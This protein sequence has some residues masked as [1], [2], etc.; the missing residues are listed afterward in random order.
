MANKYDLKIASVT[1]SGVDTYEAVGDKVDKGKTRFV[2]FV[3]ETIGTDGDSI[4]LAEDSAA[5][6]SVS[7]VVKDV[8]ILA[9]KG[10]LAFPDNVDVDNPLFSI[11]EEHYLIV[12]GDRTAATDN[13]TVVY[14]DE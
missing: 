12:K 7:P 1:L 11:D 6:G 10:I 13:V 2:C 4:T 3:K 5:D 9:A 8:T 14:F